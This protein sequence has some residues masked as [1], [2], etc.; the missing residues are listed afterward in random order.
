MFKETIRVQGKE[1]GTRHVIKSLRSIPN[2]KGFFSDLHK[3]NKTLNKNNVKISFAGTDQAILNGQVGVAPSELRNNLRHM[4]GEQIFAN[5]PIIP[6]TNLTGAAGNLKTPMYC[7]DGTLTNN[8]SLFVKQSTNFLNFTMDQNLKIVSYI[9]KF[10][11]EHEELIKEHCH[12]RFDNNFV[13]DVLTC[14]TFIANKATKT[15]YEYLEQYSVSELNER[16]LLVYNNQLVAKFLN[17]TDVVGNRIFHYNEILEILTHVRERIIDADKFEELIL[18]LMEDLTMAVIEKLVIIAN[19]SFCSMI[20]FVAAVAQHYVTFEDYFEKII[21]AILHLAG[22]NGFR[23]ISP[24]V[25]LMD[26]ID[27]DQLHL[28]VSSFYNNLRNRKTTVT[29]CKTCPGSYSVMT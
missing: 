2:I 4:S 3:V 9:W 6:E 22:Q 16:L 26:K 27:L 8:I 10:Y 21:T 28:N 5:V 18:C 29:K 12:I 14:I 15:V 17:T 7:Q 20:E 1:V 24:Y 11:T 25:L 19:I 23:D 13:K